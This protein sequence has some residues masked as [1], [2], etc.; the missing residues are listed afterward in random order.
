MLNASF[1]DVM[2]TGLSRYEE[3]FVTS[4]ADALREVIYGLLEDEEFN[5]AITYGP[6]DA[7][8]VKRRF[9][10]VREALQ[11]TLGDYAH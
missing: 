8:N 6:N 3:H 7:R 4:G 11:E 2:S 10:M 9:A 1:W 5:S